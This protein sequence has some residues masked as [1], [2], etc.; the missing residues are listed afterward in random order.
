MASSVAHR[1]AVARYNDRKYERMAIRV[2]KGDR[3][4]LQAAAE[5][6]GM[7]INLFVLRGGALS[8]LDW[9]ATDEAITDERTED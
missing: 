7:S 2:R 5:S 3:E 8:V 6:A 4:K 1:A 9:L